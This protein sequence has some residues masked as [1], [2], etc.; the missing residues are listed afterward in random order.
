MIL[1][2]LNFQKPKSENLAQAKDENEKT[3]IEKVKSLITR[4][5]LRRLVFSLVVPFLQKKKLKDGTGLRLFI[6]EVIRDMLCLIKGEKSCPVD[7][8]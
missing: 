1:Y 7:V 5:F 4:K 3:K 6:R 8:E 2:F